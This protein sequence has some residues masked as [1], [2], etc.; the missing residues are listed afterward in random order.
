[1]LL[2]ACGLW[3]VACWTWVCCWACTDVVDVVFVC[4]V[5]FALLLVTDTVAVIGRC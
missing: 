5:T 4:V 2:M 1:M 3:L